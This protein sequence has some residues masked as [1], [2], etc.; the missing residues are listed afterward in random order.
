MSQG[1]SNIRHGSELF[2]VHRLKVRLVNEVYYTTCLILLPEKNW[3]FLT[4]EFFFSYSK[5][6]GQLSTR[7][8]HHQDNSPPGQLPTRT[9]PHQD[10]SPLG[11][12]PTRTTSHQD[13]S[14]PGQFPT[15][16]TPHQDNSPPGQLP[17]RTIH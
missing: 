9:T 16:T 12:F 17:T 7:A 8:T 5:V 15:R 6:S 10:I 14:P 11:Q 13:I 4:S 2:A 3:L 1:K